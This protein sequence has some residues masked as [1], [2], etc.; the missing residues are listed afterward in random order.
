MNIH[1]FNDWMKPK[2]ALTVWSQQNLDECKHKE[3]M[4]NIT[5]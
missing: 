2:G 5:I 1:A 4:D 3:G